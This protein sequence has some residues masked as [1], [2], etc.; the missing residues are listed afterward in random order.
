MAVADI[1]LTP[2][3]IWYAPVGEAL[4]DENTV[5]YG[6]DWGGNWESFGYTTT[7]LTMAVNRETY[8]VSVEQLTIPVKEMI[9]SES[10]VFE[11]TLAE[12]TSDNVLLAFGGTLTETPAGAGQRQMWEIEMGGETDLDLWAFGFEGLYKT[13][14]NENFPVRIFLYKANVVLNGQLQFS[15]SQE[16]GIPIQITAKPDDT[17]AAG[18]QLVK[19]QKVIGTATT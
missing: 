16:A 3:T 2:A 7:P 12:F 9:T 11:S 15:K 5:D 6:E 18:K 19:I 14:A 1:L 17:K 8:E 10:L 13:D 4:P